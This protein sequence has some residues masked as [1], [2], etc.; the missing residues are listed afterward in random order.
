MCRIII[1]GTGYCTGSLINNTNNDGRLLLL[2]ANHCYED[3]SDL[4]AA[5]N[6]SIFY[7]EYES[8]SC[9]GG[10]GLTTNSI[11]GATYRANW[12][13]S[14][15]FIEELSSRPGGENLFFEGWDRNNNA[16]S[17]ETGI[18]HPLGDVKKISTSSNALTSTA[19]SS[20][21]VV[22]NA[23][24]WRIVWS[25]GVTEGGSSG[26]PLYNQD[27][28]V[29]GQ[30]HGGFSSCTATSS[31]DWYGKLFS[32]WTGAGTSSTRLS[33]WLDPIG[34]NVTTLNG[35]SQIQILPTNCHVT[36]I[37]N[38]TLNSNANY[39]DCGINVTNVTVQNNSNLNLNGTTKVIIN[40]PFI[41]QPGSTL[42]IQ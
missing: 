14:D 32:S 23:N 31:P 34:T 27:H 40:G 24:H 37:Q 20:N 33:N 17:N 30:L 36:N 25:S 16:A 21:T 42:T 2:T 3:Y 5:A 38:Q 35:I 1:N 9:N 41:V 22:N 4:N 12:A 10:D 7:F 13:N 8:P 29:V 6:N 19:W 18:H 11:S 39:T 15:F 26:S 28:R